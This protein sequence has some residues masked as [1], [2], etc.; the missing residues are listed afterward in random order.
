MELVMEVFHERA[1]QEEW[2]LQ[3]HPWYPILMNWFGAILIAILCIASIVYWIQG[4]TVK[5]GEKMVAEAR[6]TWEEAQAEAKAADE[7]EAERIR[8]ELAE[9][10]DRESDAVAQ[11]LFGIRNF[12]AKY[13]YTE[14][15]LTTYV[16][17]AFNRADARDED[18]LTVIF[19]E[20]QYIAASSHNDIKPEYKELALRMVKEWHEEDYSPCDT[21]FQYAELT[22]YG[23]Y[24]RKGYGEDRWHA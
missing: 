22:P 20:G 8:A 9:Q 18:L 5:K 6:A 17:S 14:A 4:S 1:E 11:M 24:L 2:L 12:Q 19:A 15:D 13:N 7:A 23:I 21:S 10:I 16:R 3:K